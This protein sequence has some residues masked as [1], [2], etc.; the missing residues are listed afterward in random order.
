MALVLAGQIYS[1][2]CV[3]H[4]PTVLTKEPLSGSVVFTWKLLHLFF[5]GNFMV[6]FNIVLI[7]LV[8]FTALLFGTHRF[9]FVHKI[10]QVKNN[11]IGPFLSI[12]LSHVLIHSAM[13]PPVLCPTIKSRFVTVFFLTNHKCQ[14]IH[15]HIGWMLDVA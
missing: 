7:F 9:N 11:T 13:T 2:L 5:F 6:S 8:S 15:I 3:F 1:A 4:F 14:K 12:N 10:L